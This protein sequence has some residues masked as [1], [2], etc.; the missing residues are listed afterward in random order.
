[1]NQGSFEV[2]AILDVTKLAQKERASKGRIMLILR[3]CDSLLLRALVLRLG[4]FRPN[5][6][7]RQSRRL[8]C[9]QKNV[10]ASNGDDPNSDEVF[11]VDH[12]PS[13]S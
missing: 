6:I 1:M 2:S 4:V 11:Q 8:A 9:I 5:T 10:P 7:R 12:G 3:W 13:G